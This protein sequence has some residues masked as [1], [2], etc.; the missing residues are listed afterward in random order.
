[1]KQTDRQYDDEF[2]R[3]EYD[4]GVDEYVSACNRV[5]YAEFISESTGKEASKCGALTC[6]T[7][8]ALLCGGAYGII[9]LLRH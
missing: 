4:H 8:S 7:L 6:F 5:P 1:M 2:D 9:E 3:E